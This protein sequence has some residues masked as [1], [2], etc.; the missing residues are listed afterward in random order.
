MNSPKAGTHNTVLE[1]S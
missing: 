1:V